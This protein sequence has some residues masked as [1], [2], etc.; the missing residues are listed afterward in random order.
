M[1]ARL[2]LSALTK[3]KNPDRSKVADHLAE[4]MS[5]GLSK[6]HAC[7]LLGDERIEVVLRHDFF[8]CDTM[9]ILE[10]ANDYETEPILDKR[11]DFRRAEAERN[12]Q[13]DVD[14]PLIES[15]SVS[16][17]PQQ[18]RPPSVRRSPEIRGPLCKQCG[19]VPATTR[20]SGCSCFF[21]CGEC[22]RRWAEDDFPCDEHEP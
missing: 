21:L 16:H 4:Y 19:V 1:A 3:H 9:A 2:D 8:L 15:L 17:T 20:Y 11:R 5:N 10:M 13:M 6:D 12:D 14:L 7:Y 22:S 18:T